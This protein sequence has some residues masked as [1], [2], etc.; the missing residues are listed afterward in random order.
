MKRFIYTGL[1]SA[2]ALGFSSCDKDFE[3]LNTDPNR[4][5][6]VTPGS[7]LTPVIY[8]MS[9][10]F[11]VRSYD[12]TWEIMQV[13]LG[14][15][16]YQG[17]T[18]GVHRYEVTESAGNGTWNTC[19]KWLRNVREME[20]AAE[21]YNAPVYKA[22]AA[23]LKAYIGGILTDAFGDVPFS[24]ALMAEDGI[25]Q[26]KFDTQEEIYRSLISQLQEA[27]T[28]YA[29]GGTMTGND[30]LYGNSVAKWRKF[31]NSLLMRMLLR[32]S[33]R[34]E[35]NT[36]ATLKQLIADPTTYPVFTSNAEA[37]LVKITGTSPY[38]YAW[39]RRQD[40]V[41]FNAMSEYFVN[42]LNNQEDP[43]RPL[44]M[45]KATK[46]E[47]NVLV[48]IGYVGIPSAHSGDESQF[49]FNPST[50][51][52]DLMIYTTLG[53]EIIEVIMGYA[54]VEFIKAELAFRDGDM[55]AAKA[56]Y[57]KGVAA[58]ITQWKNGA[59]PA[60]YLEK[61]AIAFNS[62][63]EQILTQ[64]YIAL[65]FNDY[66]QW[67]EYRRTGYPALPKTEY[68]LHNGVMPTRFMYHNDVRRFNADNHRIAAERIG[69]DDVMTKVWW[70][71]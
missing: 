4:I 23:T 25:T 29:A 12:F 53:T 2:M 34:T 43:R 33:K 45:T 52:G 31:N 57:D 46:L 32:L 51:N 60:G 7:L 18:G 47:N 56:A 36:L 54:E 59:V 48:D 19:Y 26:P 17:S 6:K 24:E 13:G 63:L 3:E 40:Y 41:N 71:K 49:K 1:V 50:P 14:F 37:A 68:M 66:Q 62:S 64:K 20:A 65:T 5:D 9:T 30:L 67:F 61:P 28:I 70:E 69:G 22:V 38:D 16:A 8:N 11:T 55:T 58:G 42:L 27:N 21:I 44:F 10:Y 15:G 35:L 39:A